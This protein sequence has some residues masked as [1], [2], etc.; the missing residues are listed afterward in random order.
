MILV[1]GGVVCCVDQG[2]SNNGQD[3]LYSCRFEMMMKAWR[4]E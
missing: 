4:R 2:E 1:S 3:A